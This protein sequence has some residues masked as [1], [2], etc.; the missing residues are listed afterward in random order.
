MLTRHHR[1]AVSPASTMKEK[2][3]QYRVR[4]TPVPTTRTRG[5]NYP[6]STPGAV[7][8]YWVCADVV[9]C[10][11]TFCTLDVM[12]LFT[13]N[14]QNQRTLKPEEPFYTYWGLQTKI[15]ERPL[16][17]GETTSLPPYYSVTGHRPIH[18]VDPYRQ[19]PRVSTIS[20][21]SNLF[22]EMRLNSL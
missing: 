3:L 4:G 18:Q 12:T 5:T 15:Q 13:L 8:W 19:T 16:H 2:P 11:T 9:L 7:S 14:Q 22:A 10:V 20:F 1:I 6:E 21:S 17:L